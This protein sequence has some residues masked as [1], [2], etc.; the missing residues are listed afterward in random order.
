MSGVDPDVSCAFR[1]PESPLR[2]VG[3]AAVVALEAWAE[4]R[5][6]ASLHWAGLLGSNGARPRGADDVSPIE[7][8]TGVAEGTPS[9][10]W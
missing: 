7:M 10:C 9:T 3:E 1:S 8:E 5:P 2:S 4:R 6:T